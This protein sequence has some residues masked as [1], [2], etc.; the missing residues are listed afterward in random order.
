MLKSFFFALLILLIPTSLVFS[1]PSSEDTPCCAEIELEEPVPVKPLFEPVKPLQ[2][3]KTDPIR[4]ISAPDAIIVPGFEAGGLYHPAEMMVGR[5]AGLWVSGSWNSYTIRIRGAQG[6]PLII[7][8]NMPFYGDRTDA[9]VN[10]LLQTIPTFEIKS[11]EVLKSV[12]QTAIYGGHAGN[13]VIR[14]R[15]KGHRPDM[16]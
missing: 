5:V 6:P 13:G 15:T 9:A 14:I 7:I 2:R 16:E 10:A 3:K 11:I 8:D 1:N 12:A 4:S